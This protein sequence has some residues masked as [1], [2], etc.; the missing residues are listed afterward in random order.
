MSKV[1]VF[2]SIEDP[3]VVMAKARDLRGILTLPEWR[4]VVLDA[5]MPSFA[6]EEISRR[7]FYIYGNRSPD[8]VITALRGGREAMS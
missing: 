8:R 7:G 1:D 4:Q 6:A 2:Q 5:Q 3:M